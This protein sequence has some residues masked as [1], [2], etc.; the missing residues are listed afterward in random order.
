MVYSA[1][2]YNAVLGK[3]SDQAADGPRTP[4][5][6]GSLWSSYAQA[7]DGSCVCKRRK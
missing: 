2:F 6:S 4:F 5:P 7:S 1:G 3:R